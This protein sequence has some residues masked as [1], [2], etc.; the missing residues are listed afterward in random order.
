MIVVNDTGVVVIAVAHFF[1]LDLEE[2]WVRHGA[3]NKTR[4]VAIQELAGAL[5]EVK[6][7][8]VLFFHAFTGCDQ[9]SYLAGTGKKTAWNV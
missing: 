6:A 4:F 2:L 8:A 7:R 5:E 9:V 3:G 1:L